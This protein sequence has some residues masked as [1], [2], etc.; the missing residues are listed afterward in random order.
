MG[1]MSEVTQT[2]PHSAAAPP[3]K[4]TPATTHTVIIATNNS[5]QLPSTINTHSFKKK[6]RAQISCCF[7][8]STTVVN[9]SPWN[10]VTVLYHLNLIY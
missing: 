6:K 2:L 4:A 3:P 8:F 5:D 9:Q 10:A 1:T 7:K